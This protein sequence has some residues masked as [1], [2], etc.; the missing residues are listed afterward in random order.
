MKIAV[1]LITCDRPGSYAEITLRSLADSGF[2]RTSDLVPLHVFVDG[3]IPTNLQHLAKRPGIIF[4][5]LKPDE[6]AALGL[7]DELDAVRKCAYAHYR[8]IEFMS[9]LARSH[10]LDAILLLEDDVVFAEGWFDYL[11]NAIEDISSN[12]LNISHPRTQ[13]ILSL[14]RFHRDVEVFHQAGLHWSLVPNQQFWG[15]QAI[16]YGREVLSTLPNWVF[17][18]TLIERLYPIDESLCAYSQWTGVPTYTTVPSLVQ[19]IGRRTTGQS[20]W[21]HQS[22]CFVTPCPEWTGAPSWSPDSTER[23]RVFQALR[24]RGEGPT[25]VE[26]GAYDVSFSHAAYCALDEHRPRVLIFEPDPR[27]ARRIREEGMLPGALLE[28]KALGALKCRR[29]LYQSPEGPDHSS[30]RM[31]KAS[32]GPETGVP[33]PATTDILQTTLDDACREHGLDRIDLLWCH[34][35][36][37]ERDI[38]AGASQILDRTL[39]LRIPKDRF[40]VYEGQWIWPR[41]RHELPSRWQVAADF[42]SSVLFWNRSRSSRN[43]L[44]FRAPV[45]SRRE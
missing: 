9:H 30:T 21:F 25:I 37:A 2:F 7:P 35:N 22:A 3:P 36:G 44:G 42:G 27:N 43:P 10:A 24:A 14:Y 29:V 12:H 23:A 18:K 26:A 13:W 28:E 41:P 8:A 1:G 11:R 34:A 31:P 39:L 32:I 38:V 15:T 16:V 19:H 5:A 40:E 45:L 20:R 17:Q 6:R 33:F 4:H